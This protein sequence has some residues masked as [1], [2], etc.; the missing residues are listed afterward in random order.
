MEIANYYILFTIV[1]W[2]IHNMLEFATNQKNCKELFDLSFTMEK[3]LRAPLEGIS[4]KNLNH[5]FA[6]HKMTIGQICIH[7]TGWAQYFMAD[8]G[9]KP[10]ELTKWTARPVEYPLTLEDVN[11][12]IT[13]GFAAVR[14]ILSTQ[15]DD[16]LEITDDKKKGKGYIIYRLMV[17]ALAHSNQMAYLRQL[18]DPEWEFDGHFGDMASAIIR[19]KYSTERDLNIQGF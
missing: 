1:L 2:V 18:L 9:E 7:C 17:H 5:S 10:F 4:E 8:E 14:E 6:S 11:Q 3:G 13:D 15:N 16:L 12:S 19:T